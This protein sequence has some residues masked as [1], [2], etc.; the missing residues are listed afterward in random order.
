[1]LTINHDRKIERALRRLGRGPATQRK[2]IERVPY[3]TLAGLTSWD[4][5]DVLRAI[6]AAYLDGYSAA[7]GDVCDTVSHCGRH[8]QAVI[9][10]VDG[11]RCAD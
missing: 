10:A 5:A 2:L 6:E 3:K 1:M 9:S 11:S 8:G 4:L 7:G